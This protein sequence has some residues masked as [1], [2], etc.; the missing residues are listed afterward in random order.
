MKPI[1]ILLFLALPILLAMSSLAFAEV[2][3]NHS[4]GSVIIGY[5]SDACNA[6]RGGALRYNTTVTPRVI[7]LCDGSAWT[8]LVGTTNSSIQAPSGSGFFVLT[9]SIYDGNLG[10]L[11]G[12][13]AKCLAELTTKTNWKDYAVAQSNGQLTSTKVKAFLCSTSAACNNATPLAT[14][15][16]AAVGDPSKGGASF[17][18]NS[19]GQGPG[20]TSIWSAANFFG[21]DANYWHGKSSNSGGNSTLWSTEGGNLANRCDAFTSTANAGAFGTSSAND[22]RRYYSGTGDNLACTNQL[23]LVCFVHP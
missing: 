23:H 19:S 20:N 14:Y 12:A 6:G 8:R 5:D 2:S 3:A 4:T 9:E 1:F 16:F 11:N 21:R 10:G 17:T 13:D 15:Y 7:E 18:T 22:A